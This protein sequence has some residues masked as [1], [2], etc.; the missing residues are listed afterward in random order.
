MHNFV[1]NCQSFCYYDYSF[2]ILRRTF[3]QLSLLISFLLGLFTFHLIFPLETTY[4]HSLFVVT[5]LNSE[6][7]TS[8]HHMH[9]LSG[10]TYDNFM[11]LIVFLY[12]DVAQAR[13][14]RVS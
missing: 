2:T 3:L 12:T 8:F 13:V 9:L 5:T 14:F 4:V 6:N 10:C 7:L 1:Y 11:Y